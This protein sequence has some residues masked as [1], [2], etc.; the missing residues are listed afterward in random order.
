MW[1]E[2]RYLTER[3]AV[4]AW[5][6]RKIKCPTQEF[7]VTRKANV[8]NPPLGVRYDSTFLLKQISTSLQLCD[9]GPA[10]FVAR[11]G[12]VFLAGRCLWLM[13]PVLKAQF[14]CLPRDITWSKLWKKY[15]EWPLLEAWVKDQNDTSGISDIVSLLTSASSKKYV[16][17]PTTYHPAPRTPSQP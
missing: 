15:Q 5:G 7:A 13:L 14:P 10:R 16:S 3:Q 1:G 8:A 11:E 4:V 2:C 12:F 17:P 9:K 6:W